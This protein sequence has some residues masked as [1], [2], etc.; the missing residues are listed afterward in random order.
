MTPK[1]EMR[2]AGFPW[3]LPLG[4]AATATAAAVPLAWP[5]Q[6]GGLWLQA[7]PG[8]AAATAHAVET[9]ALSL[10]LA[11]PWR[12]A[13]VQ[14]FDFGIRK[15]F[16]AL[17]QLQALG[18]YRLFADAQDAARG[19]DG[20][21]RLARHRH[22]QL[23]DDSTPTL[24]DHNLHAPQPEPYQ[25]VLINADDFPHD[26]VSTQRLAAVLREAAAAGIYVLA[27]SA[28]PAAADAAAAPA[29]SP[30]TSPT[31]PPAPRIAATLAALYPQ[32][33][34]QAPA[35]ATSAAETTA[36][37]TL[38]LLG[39]PGTQ[40]L[41]QVLARHQA[42]ASLPLAPLAPLLARLRQQAAAE[43]AREPDQDFLQ[44]PVGTTLDGRESVLWRMGARCGS[45]NALML[46]M[47]GSGKSTLLNNLIVGIAERYTAQ[48]LRL[49]LMDYKDGV[50][51][52]AF[53]QHPNVER[54]FLDNED[55]AAAV[56]LLD[57]FRATIVDRND[58]FKALQAQVRSLDDY[59]RHCPQ[60]PLPRILLVVD[61][62]QRLLAGADA[63]SH[64]FANLLVDV[65]RRGRS[66][67]VHI[68]LSTQSL[69]G[70]NDVNRLL[71][72][73]SLR[74]SFKLNSENDALRVLEAR[75]TAPLDLKRFEFVINADSGKKAANVLAR[76]LPTPEVEA[77]LAAVRAVRPAALCITPVVVRSA[78]TAA[79]AAA[80]M[81]TPAT[82]A[83]N[84]AA[85]AAAA[86]TSA[87]P[88]ARPVAPP[89]APP[90]AEA[91]A[92]LSAAPAPK[93]DILARVQRLTG[94]V[95]NLPPLQ[96]VRAG[97][98]LP[99]VPESPV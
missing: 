29:A 33:R 93:E 41:A 60:A 10:L 35:D 80:A 67:G 83:T 84:P 4:Q 17:A 81:P 58:R 50:E 37:A 16:A 11:L 43:E 53:A 95:P 79:A 72:A 39:G 89:V 66:A 96:P 47:P 13:Q 97:P 27:F 31:A 36:A 19:L 69:E 63:N 87:P 75:N 28:H 22:H 8:A 90:P 51:F 56:Q 94:V 30:A 12:H 49:Y 57:H 70:V 42:T 77:R 46:G 38:Q 24:A 55:T 6:P 86:Q 73:V 61:E 78:E 99:A 21:E 98:T 1:P 76:G 52:Q 62:A 34:L 82:P 14:V 44:V 68:L 59:N 15:R 18:L 74:A 2:H 48:Q 64:R 26:S 3:A 23:L 65:T 9:A 5:T 7:A 32:L 91:D 85:V 88:V 40:A 71:V 45:Y 92:A 20:L 25:L 54:I